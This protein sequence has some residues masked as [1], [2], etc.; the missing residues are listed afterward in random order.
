MDSTGV[1]L[2]P[3]ERGEKCLGNGK[4]VDAD[5]NEIECCCDECDYLMYCFPDND[6][7]SDV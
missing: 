7:E 3:S 5:G 6:Y 4:C 1:L 2:T